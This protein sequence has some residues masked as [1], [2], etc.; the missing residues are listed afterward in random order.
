[1]VRSALFA[2]AMEVLLPLEKVTIFSAGE[3]VDCWFKKSSS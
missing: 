3:F 1:M 2:A